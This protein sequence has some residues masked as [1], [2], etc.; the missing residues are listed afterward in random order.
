MNYEVMDNFDSAP[1][2]VPTVKEVGV[3]PCKC[4]VVFA[5]REE[6]KR[7]ELKML[8]DIQKNIL[9]ELAFVENHIV[10]VMRELNITVEEENR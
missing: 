9:A 4:C 7:H 3:Q 8:R 5:T 6:A 1:T 10:T 2:V